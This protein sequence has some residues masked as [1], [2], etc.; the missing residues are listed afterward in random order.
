M[1]RT[2]LLALAPLVG[3]LADVDPPQGAAPPT[4][5]AQS[6][7]K[8]DASHT[9]A[10]RTPE[11]VLKAFML[12]LFDGDQEAIRR[13]ALPS[14]DLAVLWQADK[15]TVGQKAIA[16]AQIN[17]S[18]PRRL[19]VGETVKLPGGKKLVIDANRVNDRTLMIDAFEAPVPFILVKA[20]DEWKVDASPIIAARKAAAMTR[21]RRASAGG[22]NW[23]VDPKL[24]DRLGDDTTVEG[25]KFRPPAGYHQIKVVLRSGQASGWMGAR[26]ANGTAAS[27]VVNV[28]PGKADN[29]QALGKILDR[30]LGPYKRRYAKDWTRSPADRGKLAGQASVRATWSGTCTEGP[31]ELL[32]KAMQGIVYVAASGDKLVQVLIKSE[33]SEAQTTLPLCEASARTLQK[34]SEQ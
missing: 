9:T 24:L 31:K 26:R 15:L 34:V 20:G 33:A 6:A 30:S 17:S 5:P 28:I 11:D 32:G 3:L 25:F 12:A 2:C 1:I 27:I 18:R 23:K 4:T 10:A 21:Q 22:D 19:K 8:P 16:V 13:T 7:T 14:P 29:E